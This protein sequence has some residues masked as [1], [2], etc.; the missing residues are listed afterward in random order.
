VKPDKSKLTVKMEK[1]EWIPGIFFLLFY[2]V[3]LNAA[4]ALVILITKTEIDYAQLN[5]L[6][7]II[8]T[9]AALLLFRRFWLGNLRQFRKKPLGCFGK[10]MACMA[11]SYMASASAGILISLLEP[12]FANANNETLIN[13]FDGNTAGLLLTACVL[14]PLLEETVFRGMIFG[15]L[16]RISRPGAYIATV[17]IFSGIHIV[18][19]LDVLSPLEIVISFLQY[20]PPAFLLCVCYE[21]CDS[22]VGSVIMHAAINLVATLSLLALRSAGMM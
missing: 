5:L 12:D 7:Y 16:S 18:G 14:A 9:V 22:L 3:L 2:F 21:F 10:A 4:M 15:N 8:C 17:L 13:T 19:Y 20:A 6:F 11:L 1:T